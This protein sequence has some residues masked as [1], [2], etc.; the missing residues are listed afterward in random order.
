MHIFGGVL[1]S[2]KILLSQNLE[3]KQQIF[4]YLVF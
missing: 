4:R 3:E 2:V 1:N